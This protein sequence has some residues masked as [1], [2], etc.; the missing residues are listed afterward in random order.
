M[1]AVAIVGRLRARGVVLKASGPHLVVQAPEGAVGEAD[2]D[3]LRA[4]KPA[5]LRLLANE[6]CGTA[7]EPGWVW[8]HGCALP[9]E[10]AGLDEADVLA[11]IAGQ[12]CIACGGH[13]R[14]MTQAA[15]M[16]HWC[17]ACWCRE[18]QP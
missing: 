3:E 11:R 16:T 18:V 5:V 15:D 6:A 10:L 13:A 2:V 17:A 1:D 9:P 4:A 8:E 7:L 14:T 12:A